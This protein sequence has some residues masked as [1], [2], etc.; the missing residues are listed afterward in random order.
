M[1][2]IILLVVGAVGVIAVVSIQIASARSSSSAPPAAAATTAQQQPLSADALAQATRTPASAVAAKRTRQ[3]AAAAPAD[4]SKEVNFLSVCRYSHRGKDDPIVFP[5]QPGQSHSHDF[6]ANDTTAANSTLGSLRAGTTSCRRSG[7]T[8]GYW[9]PTLYLDGQP[10]TPVSVNAYYRTGGKD[11]ASI[12][13]P[14]AGLKIVA[15]NAKAAGPQDP[16]ITSFLCADTKTNSATS[17]PTCPDAGAHSLHMRVR[18]PDCWNG[19]DLDSADHKSHVAYSVRGACP[20]GYPVPIPQ[21]TLNVRYPIAGGA[22]VTLASGPFYTA[23]ADFFNAW[24]QTQ[25]QSL[26][27]KCINASVHCGARGTGE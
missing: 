2:R 23:H 17:V 24:D 21:L 22:G 4:P 11:V 25:L 9:V 14:P 13:A 7:D 12:Q 19:V 18:F 5:D 10:V 27:Q 6:F 8:A 16:R 15:G 20:E 3:T 1:K 26:V